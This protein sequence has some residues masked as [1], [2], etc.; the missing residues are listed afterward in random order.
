M[1]ERYVALMGTLLRNLTRPIAA[2]LA[3]GAATTGMLAL[4]STP[5]AA[6]GN[7]ADNLVG[8]ACQGS[9]CYLVYERANGVLVAVPI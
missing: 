6:T 8:V 1:S 2:F 4:T 3:V 5:A 7:T 9:Q